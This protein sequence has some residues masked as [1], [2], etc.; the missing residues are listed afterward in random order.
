MEQKEF[1]PAEVV[2]WLYKKKLATKN[3]SVNL[4]LSSSQ[5]MGEFPVIANEFVGHNHFQ[6]YG[7]TIEDA[8]RKLEAKKASQ[9]ADLRRQ[10]DEIDARNK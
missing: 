10:A 9:A 7:H 4:M 2:A 3:S 6:V 5:G 1:D 8:L